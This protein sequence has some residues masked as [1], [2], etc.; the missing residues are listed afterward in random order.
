MATDPLPGVG[1]DLRVI[2]ETL[3]RIIPIGNEDPSITNVRSSSTAMITR[4]D[5][6]SSGARPSPGTGEVD[7]TQTF[8]DDTE[9][10]LISLQAQIPSTSAFTELKKRVKALT[11]F[12]GI[13]QARAAKKVAAKKVVAKKVVAKKAAP[14]KV[15]AK[16]AAAKKGTGKKGTGK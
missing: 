9:A 5:T 10:D 2:D 6:I 11:D 4:L 1:D 13:A 15:A 16:K 14:K 7:P 3:Q 8:L 12:V